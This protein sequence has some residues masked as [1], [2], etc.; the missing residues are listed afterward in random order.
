MIPFA[1]PG[2]GKGCDLL[3]PFSGRFHYV[4]TD[5]LALGLCLLDQGEQAFV[6]ELD[7]V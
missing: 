7:P 4:S 3:H 2:R 5:I 1:R 6:A